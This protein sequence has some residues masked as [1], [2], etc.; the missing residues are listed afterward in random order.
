MSTLRFRTADDKWLICQIGTLIKKTIKQIK[1]RYHLTTVPI[2]WSGGILAMAPTPNKLKQS[3]QTMKNV[4][5]SGSL[6]W[7]VACSQI[8]CSPRMGLSVCM[9]YFMQDFQ[10]PKDFLHRCFMTRHPEQR[11]RT[12]Q[13]LSKGGAE[14]E[15]GKIQQWLEEV[16]DYWSWRHAQTIEMSLLML[17][18]NDDKVMFHLWANFLCNS[19]VEWLD[20][21]ETWPWL[22][23]INGF[24]DNIE[25]AC[26]FICGWTQFPPHHGIEW[27]SFWKTDWTCSFAS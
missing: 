16:K 11:E 10:Q 7:S 25:F 6:K 22:Y 27:F 23:S 20:H 12:S 24:L 18:L 13:I 5:E 14:L 26:C 17:K 1:V 8:P 9:L 21:W 4:I 19:Y 2:L 3:T 15:K